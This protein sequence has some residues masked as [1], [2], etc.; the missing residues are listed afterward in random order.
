MEFHDDVVVIIGHNGATVPED[1]QYY[2]FF[3]GARGDGHQSRGTTLR[4]RLL[5]R[6]CGSP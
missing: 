2:L 6:G 4:H 1:D 3:G 5:R